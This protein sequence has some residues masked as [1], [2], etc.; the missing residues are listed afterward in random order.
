[1]HTR[2]L[3]PYQEY[4]RMTNNHHMFYAAAMERQLQAKKIKAESY[5]ML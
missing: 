2:R 1:M 3:Y 5:H 4:K